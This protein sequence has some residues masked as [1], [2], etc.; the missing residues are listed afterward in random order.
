[1]KTTSTEQFDSNQLR[2][3]MTPVARAHDESI[4]EVLHRSLMVI[5]MVLVSGMITLSVIG[6]VIYRCLR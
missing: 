1:M 5:V 2:A 3:G 4:E 6:W